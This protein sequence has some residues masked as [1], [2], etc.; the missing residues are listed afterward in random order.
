MPDITLD[1]LFD[2]LRNSWS[3]DTA[4]PGMFWN[5]QIPATGQ[6]AVTA[7]VV[8]DY[9]GGELLRTTNPI[10]LSD[11]R[12][13]HY[14]NLLPGNREVDLTRGQFWVWEPDGIMIRDRDYV[15]SFPDTVERYKL[16]SAAVQRRFATL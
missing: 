9:F 12:V 16:L 1:A 6:C 13:S 8:Q 4:A 10:G 14:F 11:S 15:L 3:A 7:L 2:A 5:S